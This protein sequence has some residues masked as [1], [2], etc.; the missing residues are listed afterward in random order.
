[1][2]AGS[3]LIRILGVARIERIHGSPIGRFTFRDEPGRLFA[4]LPSPV[5]H[6]ACFERA[7][8]SDFAD[9]TDE[10]DAD[11]RDVLDRLVGS[12]LSQGPV[13]VDGARAAEPGFLGLRLGLKSPPDDPAGRLVLA[14]SDDQFGP[15]C[16]YFGAPA[17]AAVFT[18]DGHS[19]VWVW[20]RENLEDQWPKVLCAAA[21]T[22]PVVET[23]LRWEALG[24]SAASLVRADG[25]FGAE[26]P[27][28][29][30]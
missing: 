15:C 14:A 17:R 26:A 21:G 11:F 12:L 2:A 3:K 6:D 5:D 16:A 19:I 23:K 22:L 30:E 13:T 18:D 28:R 1:V 10:W 7:G 27:S 24:P 25:P 8:F 20:L 4:L 29:I 9:S